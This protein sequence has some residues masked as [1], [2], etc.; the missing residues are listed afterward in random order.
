MLAYEECVKS[1]ASKLIDLRA[2][3]DSA[4]THLDKSVRN[5]FGQPHRSVERDLKRMQISVVHTD[6]RRRR[7]RGRYPIPYAS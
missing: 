4:F 6:D 3:F 7:I 5:A 2:A 1:G